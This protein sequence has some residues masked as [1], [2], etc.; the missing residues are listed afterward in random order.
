MK[1]IQF[2]GYVVLILLS[3]AIGCQKEFSTENGLPDVVATGS[4][5]DTFDV[6]FADSVHGTF[7]NGV[8]AGP[9]TAYVE[10]KVNVTNSGSYKIESDLQIGLKFIDS[11]YFAATGINTVLLRPIGTANAPAPTIFTISFD[12]TVCSFIVDVQ[13]STGTGLGGTDTSGTGPV[14]DD[15]DWAFSDSAGSYIGFIDTSASETVG[16]AKFL[17]IAGTTEVGDTTFALG[18]LFPAGNIAAGTYTTA[19]G[20][21]FAFFDDATSNIIYQAGKDESF[22]IKV[23][24]YSN[25]IVT[26]TFSGDA[27]DES[28]GIHAISSGTFSAFA[29]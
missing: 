27:V 2:I 13:D 23:T 7:Y 17:T 18:I 12:S 20:S 28:G 14:T 1:K 5:R 19:G 16:S 15:G 4:L 22:T 26:G 3:A 25:G 21:S 6:C 8:V 10:I 11:G 9:D 24:D 29:Q